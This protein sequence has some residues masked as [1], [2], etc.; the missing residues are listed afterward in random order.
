[1]STVTPIQVKLETTKSWVPSLSLL[2][3]YM[4]YFYKLATYYIIDCNHSINSGNIRRQVVGYIMS[5]KRKRRMKLKAYSPE[6]NKYHLMFNN[7]LSSNSDLLQR[8][9]HKGCCILNANKYNYKLR[10]VIE[11]EDGS[12]VTKWT[13]FNRQVRGTL[14][15]SW[16]ILRKLVDHTNIG[17]AIG[18]LLNLVYAPSKG[19]TDSVGSTTSFFHTSMV[20]HP[21]SDDL[22]R[23]RKFI[24]KGLLSSLSKKHQN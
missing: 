4:K 15:Y 22:L 17:R 16:M 9:T 24:H 18:R 10:S 21:G 1:M 20:V 7:V 3:P 19:M 2:Q 5:M 13:W 11:Q 14:L 6:E 23:I 12:K 8:N